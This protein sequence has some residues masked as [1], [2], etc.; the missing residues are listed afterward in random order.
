MPAH[1]DDASCTGQA[2]E[3]L[4]YGSAV[5]PTSSSS[6]PNTILR[7]LLLFCDMF[8]NAQSELISF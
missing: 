8:Q 3:S 4:Q 7:V 6:R 5:S 1:G 2:S